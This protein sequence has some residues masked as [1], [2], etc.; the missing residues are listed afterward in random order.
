MSI[1]QLCYTSFD[2]LFSTI[3]RTINNGAKIITLIDDHFENIYAFNNVDLPIFT[4]LSSISSNAWLWHKMLG[5]TS[6]HYLENISQLELVIGL[7][8]QKFE[9]DHI[10]DACELGKQ[11]RHPFKDKDI[12][13]TSKPLCFFTWFCLVLLQLLILVEK[14]RFRNCG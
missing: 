5:H 13:S 11:T 8:K 9:E 7:P 1:S 4:C 6:M 12:V 3:I 10:C 14:I 2:V